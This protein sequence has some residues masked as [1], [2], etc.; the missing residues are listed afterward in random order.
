VADSLSPLFPIAGQSL[1]E[2]PSR[3]GRVNGL[4]L[5]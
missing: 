2:L 4:F 3:V 5:S 1:M